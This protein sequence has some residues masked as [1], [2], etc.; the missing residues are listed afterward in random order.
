MT[1]E[2]EVGEDAD[3]AHLSEELLELKETERFLREELAR[4]KRR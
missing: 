3:L 2:D 4:L 1:S